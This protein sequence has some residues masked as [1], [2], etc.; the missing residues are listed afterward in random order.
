M[1]GWLDC[2]GAREAISA[3]QDGEDPGMDRALLEAHLEACS[4]CRDWADDTARV[5]RLATLAPVDLTDCGPPDLAP[6]VLAGL[7][8]PERARLRPVLRVAL[9]VVG[10]VQL[11]V[12]LIGLLP[13]IDHGLLP[14]VHGHLGHET[15]AFNIAVGAALC[16]VV[17]NTGRARGP[18]P[19][20]AVFVAVLAGMEVI[21]LLVGRV[22]WIRSVSHLPVLAGLLLTWALVRSEPRTD[23]WP[24]DTST[25]DDEYDARNEP[26]QPQPNHPPGG[27]SRP[28]AARHRAA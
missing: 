7:R 28:P 3:L 13:I 2:E 19:L 1:T 5:N 24:G 25:A 22:D 9:L 17:A 27:S 16:W 8:R 26:E 12:G 4:R 14:V 23:P 10:L 6:A 11:A 20:L 21:D 15:A 18:L